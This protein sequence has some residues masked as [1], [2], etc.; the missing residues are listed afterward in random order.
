MSYN[1]VKVKE[2]QTVSQSTQTQ[3]LGIVSEVPMNE[4]NAA[5]SYEKL[6]LVTYKNA[7]FIAKR[8]NAGI[9]PLDTDGW[10]DVWMLLKAGVGISTTA[11]EYATSVTTITE[12][13]QDGWETAFPIFKAGE[14]IWTR[15][16]ITYTDNTSTVLYSVGVAVAPTKTSELVNDGD[17]TSPFA[18]EKQLEAETERAEGAEKALGSRVETIEGK[19]P[20]QAS[21]AD[22]LATQSFV[23]SSINALAAFF[24]T[25]TATG[26]KAFATRAALLAATTFYSGGKTRVPTQNDYA[27]VLADES[28]A[29]GVDG[30]YPTTRYSYQGGTYPAGQWD[31]Q[32]IVNN[33][34]L[35]QAQVDA[36]NSGITAAGV[37]Q[38]EKNR[39][40]AQG[41]QQ[42]AQDAQN[43]ANNAIPKT[44]MGVANGV[45]TLGTDGKVPS[46]QLP[47]P[48]TIPTSLPPN[49]AAGGDLAGTYPN[50]SI[51]SA[52]KT[53]INGAVQSNT[54]GQAN[55]VASLGE[56]GKV[57]AA[58]LPASATGDYIPTS[59]KGK[60]GGVA[61]MDSVYNRI[62]MTGE[63][64][65]DAYGAPT[66]QK[67]TSRPTTNYEFI[68]VRVSGNTVG[69]DIG[70]DKFEI[71][72][73]VS[74]NSSAT[75]LSQYIR[76][77]PSNSSYVRFK[78]DYDYIQIAQSSNISN[79][80]VFGFNLGA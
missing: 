77:D 52:L 74:Y 59:Q 57:P 46:T 3:S 25:P 7:T 76:I 68:L 10:Q 80:K 73:M 12:P 26:D 54:K 75:A 31:F 41:A 50:P 16:T 6:N 64:L 45:A 65:C 35:T 13:P 17:G 79:F 47:A 62:T 39:L 44:E 70:G 1:N 33:T 38:I 49:G 8:A 11:V 61:K 15:L 21:A 78:I 43:T 42:A 19:I 9:P 37:G 36:L 56:D 51:A 22:Q 53:L 20:T 40:A 55:G 24:I 71:V 58:Q 67:A 27:I 5:V 48:P 14:L 2:R 32:Y 63:L 29:K 30:T 28:Q 23:N 4:W 72:P 18:T 34:S 60:A 69:S 66:G